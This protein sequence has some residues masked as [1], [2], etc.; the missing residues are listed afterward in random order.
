MKVSNSI[1]DRLTFAEKIGQLFIPA[2]FINADDAHVRYIEN[3]ITEYHIGGLTFFHSPEMA[4]TNYEKKNNI[5]KNDKSHERLK[6]LIMHYQSISKYPMLMSIDA[7][8]GLAMRVEN[9]E[10]Y[11]YS[12][13]LGALADPYQAFEV[14]E[15][16]GRDLKAT[17]IHLNLAPVVDVNDNP[18]NPVI[19]YRSFGENKN[20]VADMACAFYRGM[21]SVG[22]LGCAKHFPG[23]G[24]T[25][26]DSHLS[27]PVISK[28]I[29]QLMEQ[30]LYP[31]EKI[32]ETQVDV[33]MPGHLAVPALTG[34][35]HEPASL[36]KAIVTNLLK[37]QLGF[38][39]AVMSDALNMHAVSKIFELPGQLEVAA[40]EAGNDLL[41]FSQ[42]IPA[43][44]ELI[45][46]KI[47][48]ERIDQSFAQIENLKV[49]AGLYENTMATAPGEPLSKKE[50]VQLKERI[51]EGAITEIR[52]GAAFTKSGLD[53]VAC[54]AMNKKAE[55]SVFAQG[56]S[57]LRTMPIYDILSYSPQRVNEMTASLA[58]YDTLIVGLYIPNI[59][60]KD[61]FGLDPAAVIWLNDMLERKKTHL[62]VFGSPYVLESIDTL[63]AQRALLAYQDMAEFERKAAEIVFGLSSPT[64]V[65]PVT[66]NKLMMN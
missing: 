12:L 4:A 9:T 44:V 3:L 58:Q 57:H 45:G 46:K 10:Q 19:G 24:N 39:G 63:S 15:A 11:P 7:E 20:K 41:S 50:V 55:L 40:V 23:H 6:E 35:S 16:I 14:G 49:K 43:A 64:G 53:K 38:K 51:A 2:A 34:A 42:H 31:F 26:V 61:N 29:E 8:W 5:P 66:I 48:V 52:Q 32:I 65:L 13:T 27:L 54:L 37:Q 62:V 18:D 17:G 36:S 33:V 47:D 25:S 59:K 30:E 28:A 56:I 1:S 60:P 22:V 21:K